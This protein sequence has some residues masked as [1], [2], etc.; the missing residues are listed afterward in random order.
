MI[1]LLRQKFIPVCFL[2][3]TL[4]GIAQGPVV[5][6]RQGYIKGVGE[7]RIAVFKGIPYAQPPVGNLRYQPPAPH[8]PWSDTLSTV[9]FPAAALQ[10]SGTGVTGSEDCLYLNL[11]TPGLDDHKRAVVIWVH[12][13][14]MTGGTG[15]SMDGHAFADRDD[16]V[17]I[18]INYRLGALGFL[19]LGGP[20]NKQSGNLGLLDVI[21]A[22]Q[23]VHD[24]ITVFGGDPSRVTVMGE[25]AGAKLLSAVMVTP[26]SQG[27]YQQAILESGAVQCIRDSVTARNERTLLLKQLGLGPKDVRKLLTID[28]DTLMRAQAQVCA[29]IGGNSF[30]GPVYDGVTIPE[31]G[32]LYAREGKLSGI[33]AIIGT[34]EQEGAAFIGREQMGRDLNALVFQPLFRANAPMA[35]AYYQTLLKTDSPYAAMVRTL[36][37]YMYQMH[38]Y[39]F[40]GA[41]TGAGAPAGSNVPGGADAAADGRGPVYMYRYSYQN[42]RAFGARHGDELHYIWDAN[43]I[44]TSNDDAARKQLARSLHG[45]WVNFIKTGDPNG[46]MGDPNGKTGDPNGTGMPQWPMYRDTD[47]QVMVFND[48]DGVIRLQE[49]YDDKRFPS[50][51]FVLK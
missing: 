32:Y 9:Q 33:K 46:T 22:L 37:Q 26:A 34:N 45:A 47:R 43:H 15:K 44:L 50:A 27:L 31:D 21:A 30:F 48:V 4:S 1:M 23:W 7:N 12:G 2:L 10:P 18:T 39:R 36:T 19:Y 41:L 11:Y 24:N 28:A 49:V 17:T 38:S 25:S 51:V 40:A 42:G 13:G 8:Q 5:K 3:V 16:I 20:E 14:S 29:G 35:N 6:T